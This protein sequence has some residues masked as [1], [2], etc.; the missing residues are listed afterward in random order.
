MLGGYFSSA[1]IEYVFSGWKYDS[2][3][4][5]TVHGFQLVKN[6]SSQS[7]L[8]NLTHRAYLGDLEAVPIQM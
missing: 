6:V 8:H 5:G 7:Y 3:D 4:L 1:V 2:V